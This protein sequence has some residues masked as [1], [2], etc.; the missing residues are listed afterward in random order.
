M[1]NL[2]A[3]GKS[4]NGSV[5]ASQILDTQNNFTKFLQF[6]VPTSLDLDRTMTK[7]GHQMIQTMAKKAKWISKA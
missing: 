6:Q 1:G 3:L 2:N 7:L 4:V 5:S